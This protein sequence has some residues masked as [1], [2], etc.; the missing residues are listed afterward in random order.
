ML[1]YKN[2]G[3]AMNDIKITP[4]GTADVE[5]IRRDLPDDSLFANLSDLFKVFG[6]QTRVKILYALLGREMCV[7]DIA[8][9]LGITV[10][11][12]SHQL[13]IL[14]QSKLVKFRRE[15]QTLFYSLDDDHVAKIISQ[16]MDH[17]NE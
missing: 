11:A 12:I 5:N 2:K 6:D 16:G 7:C 14:K 13:R 8:A 10:S 9:L 17:I 4:N 3:G 15:G 1:K